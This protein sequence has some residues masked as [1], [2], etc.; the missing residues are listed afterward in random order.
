LD[1]EKKVD[2]EL[3]GKE[4]AQMLQSALR[5]K[6]GSKSATERL[7][8]DLKEVL[9]KTNSTEGITVKPVDNNLYH[10]QIRFFDFP[11]DA[12]IYKDLQFLK[13]QNGRDHV[14]LEILFNKDYPSS[15]PFIRVVGPRFCQYTGHVTIGGSICIEDLTKTGWKSDFEISSFLVMIRHLLIAGNAKVDMSQLGRDYT[16][17]EAQKAF[18]RVATYHGWES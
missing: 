2:T 18:K 12:Q 3:Y 17:K 8:S 16:L 10:W 9:K 4:E 13:D 7:V 14:L 5:P 6:N 15:P 11:S 1:P